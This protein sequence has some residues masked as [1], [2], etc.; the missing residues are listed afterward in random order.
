MLCAHNP[1]NLNGIV[2][3]YGFP[4]HRI[5]SVRHFYIPVILSDKGKKVIWNNQFLFFYAPG[6][7]I[8]FYDITDSYHILGDIV[9]VLLVLKH[10]CIVHPCPRHGDDKDHNKKQEIPPYLFFCGHNHLHSGIGGNNHCGQKPEHT[11]VHGFPDTGYYDFRRQGKETDDKKQQGVPQKNITL[12]V[13]FLE[14]KIQNR[15]K[16]QRHM[17]SRPVIIII[18]GFYKLEYFSQ[19]SLRLTL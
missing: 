6:F 19:N 11:P 12:F 4:P 10:R 17:H 13:F 18:H 3:F 8:L 5:V 15:C 2:V 16:K 14:Q 1:E 9:M 7:C